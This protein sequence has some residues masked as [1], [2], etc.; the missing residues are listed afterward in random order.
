MSELTEDQRK[1]LREL[2]EADFPTNRVRGRKVSSEECA[3]LRR[4]FREADRRTTVVEES[5]FDEGTVYKHALGGCNHEID[6]PPAERLKE[7]AP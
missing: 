1:R 2:V 7:V 3:E 6:E 4:A 5:S